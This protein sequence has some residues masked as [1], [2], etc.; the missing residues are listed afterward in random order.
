MNRNTGCGCSSH[1]KCPPMQACDIAK[2]HDHF[3]TQGPL[4]NINDFERTVI[5]A[6][7]PLTINVEADIKLPTFA[8]DIKHIRKNVHLTQCQAIPVFF[9]NSP[10]LTDSLNLYIE[11]YVHKNIQYSEGCSGNIKDHSVNVP[12]KCYQPVTGLFHFPF[13]TSQKDNILEIRDLAKDGMGSDR[14]SFGSITFENL[15]EPIECKLLR[16]RVT[17]MDFPKNFDPWG[18]FEKITEKVTV[19]LVVRLTQI[20]RRD[21]AGPTVGELFF[22]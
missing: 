13:F 22:S 18:R 4:Q 11:G 1:G 12:F 10:G 2:T 19:D 17:Q 14:C 16:A 15:N 9:P 6:D 7:V 21:D 20:Q 8:N 5:L 3:C